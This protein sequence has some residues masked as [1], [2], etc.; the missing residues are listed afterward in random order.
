MTFSEIRCSYEISKENNWDTI[1]GSTQI[2]T[3][4]IFLKSVSK[5]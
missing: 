5:L 4:D 1:I 3:P 2:L